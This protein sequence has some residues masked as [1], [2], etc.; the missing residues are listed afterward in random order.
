MRSMCGKSIDK[1]MKLIGKIHRG[2][3]GRSGNQNSH[4]MM[5]FLS[6]KT[7]IL[8]IIQR[9][10][11]LEGAKLTIF[12]LSNWILIHQ[13][14]SFLLSTSFWNHNHSRKCLMS[15]SSNTMSQGSWK[16]LGGIRT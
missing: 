13:V 8:I 3:L 10:R 6:A 16:T 7:E 9:S 14:W 5:A 15:F 2:M 12:V 1:E 4:F 11:F